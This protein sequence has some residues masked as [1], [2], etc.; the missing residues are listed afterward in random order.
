MQQR[1]APLA[2][3]AVNTEDELLT[4]IRSSLVAGNM[5]A[6]ASL[7]Q[8]LSVEAPDKAQQIIRAIELRKRALNESAARQR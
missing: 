4:A 3:G 7:I 8:Q 5:V 1:A 2:A 6:A